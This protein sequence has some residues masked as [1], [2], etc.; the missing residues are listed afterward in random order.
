MNPTEILAM[1]ADYERGAHE[2]IARGDYTLARSLLSTLDSMASDFR[3][4]AGL[5]F[6]DP[7]PREHM[8][9]GVRALH[10][11]SYGGDQ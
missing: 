5:R 1:M 11:W 6:S 4:A 9:T 2:A 3:R 8:P 10:G 7:I